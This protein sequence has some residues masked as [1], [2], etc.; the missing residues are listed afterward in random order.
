MEREGESMTSQ[1][2]LNINEKITYSRIN[3]RKQLE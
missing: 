3:A 2:S 1:F